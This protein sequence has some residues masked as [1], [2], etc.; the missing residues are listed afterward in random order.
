M[1]GPYKRV[2]PRFNK[3]CAIDAFISMNGEGCMFQAVALR[4]LKS[5]RSPRPSSVQ[6]IVPIWHPTGCALP[7]WCAMRDQESAPSGPRPGS[8]Y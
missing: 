8:A 7:M 5:V 4:T 3:G 6:M 1:R 2:T